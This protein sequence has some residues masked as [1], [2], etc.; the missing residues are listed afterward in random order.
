MKNESVIGI[1]GGMGPEATLDLFGKIIRSTPA[2]RD[3]DHLRVIID[4][5][6][7]V[8]DRTAAIVADGADPVP[9]MAASARVLET[10]GVD[11]I[12]M[13]CISAHYFLDDLQPVTGVPILSAFDAVA[14]HISH[15]YPRVEKVGLL[16]TIGTI[17]GGKLEARLMRNGIRTIIPDAA[18][19][20]QVMDAIY[21]IKGS[22]ETDVRRQC[23]ETLL[24]CASRL[25]ESGAQG[26]VAGCTEIP[27]ELKSADVP[28]P[29]FDA[30]LILAEAAVR[31]AV[32]DHG[33]T[34]A[35]LA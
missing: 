15:R 19:Q 16:S 32:P 31:R 18:G 23:R 22:S 25:V 35:A 6:P 17:T 7:K 9:V 27:L 29:Y 3:Q 12:V 5:N 33:K 14:D 34:T 28:V 4:S 10:A 20:Q 30:L 2:E 24:S 1:L 26:I 8:P 11:F 21:R 13:P